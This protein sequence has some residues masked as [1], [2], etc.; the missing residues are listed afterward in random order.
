MAGLDSIKHFVDGGEVTVSTPKSV[1]KVALDPTQTE[2]ILTNMQQYIDE[3]QSPMNTL[4]G[5]INKARAGLAGPSALTAYQR[6]QDLSDKQIMDYR[7]QMAAYRAAQTQAQN[8][9]TFMKGITGGGAGGVE[10]GPEAMA[11]ISAARNPTEAKTVYQEELK[12]LST[13]RAKGQFDAAG[14]KSEKFFLNGKSVDMTTN[15]FINLPPELKKK[16][17]METFARLGYIPGQQAAP[18]QAAPAQAAPAVGGTMSPVAAVR[19][20]ESNNNPNVAPSSKGAIGAMQVLPTTA[21]QPGFGVNPV[22]GNAPEEMERVGRDYYGAMQK[23]YKDDIT[24][25]IAYNWG[26]GNT[27]RWLASGADP[28]KLPTETKNYI[29]KFKGLVGAPA[30]TAVNKLELPTAPDNFPVTQGEWNQAKA[31]TPTAIAPVT[32]TPVTPPAAVAAPAPTAVGKPQAAPAQAAPASIVPVASSVGAE[33]PQ[34]SEA[35]PSTVMRFG[36]SDEATKADTDWEKRRDSFL[37][38]QE[39]QF[40]NISS[41]SSKA[42]LKMQEVFVKNTDPV[43]LR[44]RA[45]ITNSL[46]G[47]L[48]KYGGNDRVMGL[49]SRPELGNAILSA[50]QQGISTPVGPLG[51]PGIQ[52][53]VQAGLK[54]LTTEEVQAVDNLMAIMGPRILQI[55]EQTKGASS[56][57]DWAEYQAIAG[58][59]NSGYDFLKKASEYDK[60]SINIDKSAR[61]IW[62]NNYVSSGKGANYGMFSAD[63]NVKSLFDKWDQETKRIANT[64]YKANKIPPKPKGMPTNVKADYSPSTNSFWIG[65]TEYKVQ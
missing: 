52:R 64:T 17:E 58:N 26:P 19:T 8:D 18:A 43:T 35:R 24:A 1:G 62:D 55:V 5:G 40:K 21:K 36:S 33:I 11:R 30:E 49:M 13:A 38:N 7:G 16:I 25:A 57:K 46:D 45:Q 20:I 51:V 60:A 12:A 23:R 10:L 44:T 41:D 63:K 37:K 9:A 65:N 4:M 6:E 54:G 50:M 48:N 22:Q 32:A 42:N 56:D 53:I 14:N 27:D 47:W 39:E 29:T 2:A 28:A 59:S 3:R 61:D 15:M 31:S 34:F